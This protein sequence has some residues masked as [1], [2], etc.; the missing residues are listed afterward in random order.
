LREQ[1]SWAMQ[2]SN[3]GGWNVLHPSFCRLFTHSASL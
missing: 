3:F 1:W 2:R